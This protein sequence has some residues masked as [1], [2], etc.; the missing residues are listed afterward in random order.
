LG[1]Y[2]EETAV[3]LFCGE[4]QAL[5]RL[6]VGAARGEDYETALQ[7]LLGDSLRKKHW[8]QLNIILGTAKKMEMISQNE[9]AVY[10]PVAHARLDKRQQEV[11]SALTKK[12]LESY[13]IRRMM[14]FLLEKVGREGQYR[15]ITESKWLIPLI[16]LFSG[17]RIGEVCALRWMDFVPIGNFGTYQLLIRSYLDQKDCIQKI[18]DRTDERYRSVPVAPALAEMLL[19]YKHALLSSGQKADLLE[20]RPIITQAPV[21]EK[22][23]RQKT[24]TAVCAELVEKAKLPGVTMR[25]PDGDEGRV[26]DLGRYG[27][28]IY[29]SNIKFYLRHLC[30]FTEG[31]LRYFL[32]LTAIDTLSAHYCDYATAILQHKMAVKLSRWTALY[33]LT[34]L[35]AATGYCR[36]MLETCWEHSFPGSAEAPVSAWLHIVPHSG[37]FPE[38][39]TIEVDSRFGTDIT[40]ICF[41]ED[42][43]D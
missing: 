11:R 3:E 19:A 26:T 2:R 23:C 7:A 42:I 37:I 35:T 18:A 41:M 24:G 27:G 31:E 10:L 28:D 20:L 33:S 8:D 34:P 30:G 39:M 9:V 6:C 21:G 25:L 15:F 36:D 5:S 38:G 32:G 40:I 17:L 13:E 22:P 29:Y 43:N 12:T 16:R 1:R 4:N 14:D